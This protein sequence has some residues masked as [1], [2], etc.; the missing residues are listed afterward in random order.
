MWCSVSGAPHECI[1]YSLCP[2]TQQTNTVFLCALPVDAGGNSSEP[3]TSFKDAS[4]Q[5]IARLRRASFHTKDNK[6]LSAAGKFVV[7]PGTNLWLYQ[8]SSHVNCSHAK[9]SN[10]LSMCLVKE[11]VIAELSAEV[12][13][14]GY[15]VIIRSL[16][17][18]RSSVTSTR[19]LG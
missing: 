18:K 11:H 4:S 13:P 12:E 14:S 10:V 7:L 8:H 1:T 15:A 2:R 5:D 19:S 6:S 16:L 17:T 9:Y 3:N